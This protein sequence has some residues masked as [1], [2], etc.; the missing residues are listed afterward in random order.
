MSAFFNLVDGGLSAFGEWSECSADCG[1]GQQTRERSCNN[2]AP[3]NGGADCEGSLKEAENCNSGPCPGSLAYH[4]A[5]KHDHHPYTHFT[6]I[7]PPILLKKVYPTKGYTIS[8]F[9]LCCR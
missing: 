1:E 3:A 8:S 7:I 4:S 2:P 6:I 5:G 9:R